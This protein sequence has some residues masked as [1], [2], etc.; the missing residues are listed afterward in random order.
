MRKKSILLV[1]LALIKKLNF[2]VFFKP[3]C[4]YGCWLLSFKEVYC[5]LFLQL[6]GI[7]GNRAVITKDLLRHLQ[8]MKSRNE[9][10]TRSAAADFSLIDTCFK[11]TKTSFRICER[12]KHRLKNLFL[13]F[14]YAIQ[15]KASLIQVNVIL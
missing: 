1:S 7:T 13:F 10:S 3:L 11:E 6:L 8:C 2:L 14:C 12:S 5:K 15:F 9:S 4:C